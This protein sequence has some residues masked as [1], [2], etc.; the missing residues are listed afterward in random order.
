MEDGVDDSIGVELMKD[1][2]ADQPDE[3]T[4][5][6]IALSLLRG[7]CMW[8]AMLQCGGDDRMPAQAVMQE[9]ARRYRFW[10]WNGLELI[11]PGPKRLC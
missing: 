9:S 10:I 7:G 3:P 4:K 1:Q 5:R 11:R 8:L 6:T 2:S